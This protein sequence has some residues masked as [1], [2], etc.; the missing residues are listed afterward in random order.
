MFSVN[1]N[2]QTLPLK[3]VTTLSPINFFYLIAIKS[4]FL[5]NQPAEF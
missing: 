1:L 5:P 2:S 4:L 3:T